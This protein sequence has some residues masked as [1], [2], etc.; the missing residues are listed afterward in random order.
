MR[1]T[2]IPCGEA[3]NE[4]EAVAIDRLNRELQKIGGDDEWILLTNLAF[5]VT[6]Q[7]Q[8]DEID[9]IAIGPPGVRVVEVKH[10]SVGWVDANSELVGQEADKLTNKA[11]K[12]VTTLR[13]VVADL[14]RVDGAFLLTRPPSRVR[15]LAERTTVRGVSFHTLNQ[16][17]EAIGFS[18]PRVLTSAQIRSLGKTLAPRGAVRIDGTLRRFAGYVNLERQTPEDE[19]FHRVYRGS[20]PTRRDKVIL[21]LYDLS[22][23]DDARAETRARREAEALRRLQL[24]PWAPRILDSF[25]DAPGYAGEMFFF[26]VADPAAPPLEARAVD[27]EWSSAARAMFAREA[28]R[29]LSELHS[30]GDP[31][32]A[33][34]HRNLTPRTILVRYDNTP[35]S[36]AS[37]ERGFCRTSA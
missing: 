32:E 9:I 18:E 10:W 25:Q 29:A 31:G 17:K 6:H 30:A 4:S 16:W 12:V 8:S 19:R 20:H 37:T 27:D 11:R 5:S 36:R 26:T 34:I 14:P 23:S 3:V 15:K 1:I 28:I 22:A 33:L 7:F 13:S 35:S 24:Y 2:L 21:H